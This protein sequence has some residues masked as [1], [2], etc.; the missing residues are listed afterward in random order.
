MIPTPHPLTVTVGLASL[1][2][3][4]LNLLLHTAT[5]H[6][7]NTNSVIDCAQRNTIQTTTYSA[8]A[9]DPS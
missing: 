6:T 3:P 4:K 2:H 9:C 7:Y 1:T 8:T 5:R